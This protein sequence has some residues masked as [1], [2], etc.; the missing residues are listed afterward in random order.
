[1]EA[2]L[3]WFSAERGGAEFEVTLLTIK[4]KIL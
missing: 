4:N 1:M 2:A 3:G